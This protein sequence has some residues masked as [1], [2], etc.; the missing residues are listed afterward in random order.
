MKKTL[1][2]INVLLVARY[3]LLGDFS[4]ERNSEDEVGCVNQGNL[5]LTMIDRD[6]A[7]VRLKF[8]G[9]RNVEIRT[10]PF[11]NMSIV[12]LSIEDMSNDQWPDVRMR[13][14]SEDEH[15]YLSFYCFDADVISD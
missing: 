2:E 7:S 8:F 13:V 6:G 4:F 12:G 15:A 14:T 3:N 10:G 5:I 9:V 11:I 1:Q